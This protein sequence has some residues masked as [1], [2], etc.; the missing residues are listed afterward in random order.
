MMKI[1]RFSTQAYL[2]LTMLLV[3]YHP[4]DA[5]THHLIATEISFPTRQVTLVIWLQ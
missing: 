4:C 2:V 1:I 3:M 5:S